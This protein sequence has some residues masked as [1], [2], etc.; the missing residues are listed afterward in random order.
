MR[1]GQQC[2]RT[3]PPSEDIADDVD[4]SSDD[5]AEERVLQAHHAKV[6]SRL[7]AAPPAP[8]PTTAATSTAI[9]KPTAAASSKPA[10]GAAG[11]SDAASSISALL[12]DASKKIEAQRR[13][14]AELMRDREA[15]NAA[16][17][18]LRRELHEA[19]A[20]AGLN[21]QKV[22]EAGTMLH[23]AERLIGLAASA[24]AGS[25][26]SSGNAA[27]NLDRLKHLRQALRPVTVF[28]VPQ[29][30]W[31]AAPATPVAVAAPSAKPESPPP[32]TLDQDCDPSERAQLLGQIERLET[33]LQ[34][35]QDNCLQLQDMVAKYQKEE[36]DRESGNA[37]ELAEELARVQETLTETAATWDAK[38]R[39]LQRL[40][41]LM[42]FSVL[43]RENERLESTL[44]RAD[45]LE[46]ALHAEKRKAREKQYEV[47][48][49][50]RQLERSLAD[51]QARQLMNAELKR[52]RLLESH[53]LGI[54]AAQDRDPQFA[55]ARGAAGSGV[56]AVSALQ[57]PTS[58]SMGRASAS[59]TAS[60]SFAPATSSAGAAPGNSPRASQPPPS[61]P[62][63]SLLPPHL[64]R[65]PT[66]EDGAQPATEQKL[67]EPM[68][69]AAQ[70]PVSSSAAHPF[71]SAATVPSSPR[72]ASSTVK[73]VASAVPAVPL[74]RSAAPVQA[75]LPTHTAASCHRVPSSSEESEIIAADGDGFSMIAA[76]MAKYLNKKEEELNRSKALRKDAEEAAHVEMRQRAAASAAT[77]NLSAAVKRR[78]ASA[79]IGSYSAGRPSLNLN[80][81]GDSSMDTALQRQYAE[82]KARLDS[83]RPGPSGVPAAAAAASGSLSQRGP[84]GLLLAG[85]GGIRPSSAS[86]PGPGGR[87]TSATTRRY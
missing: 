72:A 58:A 57:R 6:T 34:R 44:Q 80:Y 65:A 67:P 76:R 8:V 16:V 86:R 85:V 27:N 3:T 45:E 63:R 54:I 39:E 36:K 84:S 59:T 17:T 35:S 13:T 26:S 12:V 60:G 31:M 37:K 1:A 53:V 62:L 55:A 19:G 49:L 48:R 7:P 69:P 15:S 2:A 40:R 10:L 78:P 28:Q 75:D 30:A 70:A 20:T 42:K 43:K 81:N 18:A 50:E 87:P 52:L 83:N 24:S 51:C 25:S 79:S 64:L 61:K 29:P 11:G 56:T 23:E 14:I 5:S 21:E 46:V 9:A 4:S 73:S 71:P 41:T 38:Q 22:R 77:I 68:A 82:L 33:G 74:Q 32:S 47:E 66:R